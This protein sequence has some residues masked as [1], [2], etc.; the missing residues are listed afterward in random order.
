MDALEQLDQLGPALGGVVSQ[1][2]ADQLDQPTPCTQLTVRGVLE[3]M[4]A[5]ATSFAAAFRGEP[6]PATDG[7]DVT[8]PV[9]VF[10]RAMATLADAMHSP[11][12]LHRTIAAP[13]GEVSGDAF[14]RF[15]VLDGLVHGWD[16]ATA[17]GQTYE[18]PAALVDAVDAFAREAIVPS[19]READMF[20]APVEAPSDA[21][22]IVR[23]V[24]FT[25]RPV[26][27][28]KQ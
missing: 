23:L 9:A 28:S 1:I 25:G 26:A 6:T 12:A 10:G 21:T 24:A 14:A 11:G 20:A 4:I 15:V 17:T 8:D 2:D 3:H 22:P 7:R 16:L 5:G 18:P 19:M 27:R 13:F